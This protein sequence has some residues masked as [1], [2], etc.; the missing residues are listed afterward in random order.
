M[1]AETLM[2]IGAVIGSSALTTLIWFLLGDRRRKVQPLVEASMSLPGERSPA[3]P[4]PLPDVK[5]DKALNQMFYEGVTF[6]HG[7]NQQRRE[8]R[9][10][11]QYVTRA[12]GQRCERARL[13]VKRENHV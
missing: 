11:K 1:S 3:P 8:V 4:A 7:M 6:A 13:K 9:R 2:L 12:A 10:N 5:I